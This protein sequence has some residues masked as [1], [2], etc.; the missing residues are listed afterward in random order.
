MHSR[1][2]WACPQWR[3]YLLGTGFLTP[4][5]PRSGISSITRR[6]DRGDEM[7]DVVCQFHD[8]SAAV[9]LEGR[10]GSEEGLDVPDVPTDQRLVFGGRAVRIVR[11]GRDAADED[12]HR[13]AQEDDGLEPVVEAA[14]VLDGPET[15]RA[16]VD[17]SSSAM[18]GS[19]HVPSGSTHP[20]AV[21]IVRR[22][23]RDSSWSTAVFPAPDIPVIRTW[24]MAVSV[25]IRLMAGQAAHHG[26]AP[27]SRPLRQVGGDDGRCGL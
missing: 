21:S 13:C 11:P 23:R 6:A 9:E 19:S 3:A 17:A 18:R 2:R 14:L 8:R 24:A 20:S 16:G 7:V 22:P 26:D 5:L 25:L 4:A 15:M 1:S 27:I 12:L 10:A